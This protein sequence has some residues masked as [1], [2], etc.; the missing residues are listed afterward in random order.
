MWSVCE[1][2]CGAVIVLDWKLCQLR[3]YRPYRRVVINYSNRVRVCFCVHFLILPTHN[4]PLSTCV[5]VL[6]PL[7]SLHPTQPTKTTVCQPCFIIFCS[8][9]Q[10]KILFFSHPF[11][12][13]LS[14][15]HW[16]HLHEHWCLI[17]AYRGGKKLRFWINIADDTFS[18]SLQQSFVTVATCVKIMIFDINSR[19]P[20]FFPLLRSL[21]DVPREKT[22]ASFNHT[23]S[24]SVGL[25][26][27]EGIRIQKKSVWQ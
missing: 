14:E 7:P 13:S 18:I 15:P 1:C 2:V 8:L 12:A 27:R 23:F 22:R 3:A 4:S 17:S 16:G 24:C 20:L 25:I 9:F 11:L 6:Y 26:R 21:S 5:F 19:I 10:S